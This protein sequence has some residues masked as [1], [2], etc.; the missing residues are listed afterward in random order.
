MLRR[1][2]YGSYVVLLISLFI[3][4][5]WTTTL[6]NTAFYS[7][8]S[9]NESFQDSQIPYVSGTVYMTAFTS[10]YESQPSSVWF[11]ASISFPR[12]TP[13][14]VT[15][16]EVVIHE[17]STTGE[18]PSNHTTIGWMPVIIDTVN[19]SQIVLDGYV[20]ISPILMQGD[21]FLG[22]SISYTIVSENHTDFGNWGDL[23]MIPVT[24]VS[25]LLQPVGW[26][27][28]NGVALIVGV[29]ILIKRVIQ[30]FR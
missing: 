2:I 25:S 29:I 30:I 23:F 19:T 6:A 20:T 12:E 9:V 28:A 3:M 21:I 26:I 27:Y 18:W 10:L 14:N 15:I 17:S 5:G 7:E 13:I 11:N 22:F 1:V 24:I 16:K 4:A 8:D